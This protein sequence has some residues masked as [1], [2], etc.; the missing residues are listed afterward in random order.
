MVKEMAESRMSMEKEKNM[1]EIW[2]VLA[3]RIIYFLMFF[4]IVLELSYFYLIVRPSDFMD[5]RD[6][7]DYFQI[8]IL[9]PFILQIFLG[10][11]IG[12]LNK[13]RRRFQSF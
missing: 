9:V 11:I 4:S 10:Y 2:D 8:V 5:G 1:N 6:L 3:K 7:V 12:R 13:K